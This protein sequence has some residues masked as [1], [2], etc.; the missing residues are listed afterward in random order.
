MPGGLL[1][2]L[3]GFSVIS[4]DFAVVAGSYRP[5]L[6]PTEYQELGPRSLRAPAFLTFGFPH[7]RWALELVSLPKTPSP[8]LADGAPRAAATGQNRQPAA[9]AILLKTPGICLHGLVSP[10]SG[11]D[12]R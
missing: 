10:H 3:P 2:D 12:V 7:V 5:V 11:T 1:P 6:G 8:F 4:F 9:L